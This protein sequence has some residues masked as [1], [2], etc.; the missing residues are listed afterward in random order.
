MT[1]HNRKKKLIKPALQ[2]KLAGIFMG[3]ALAVVS[4]QAYTLNKTTL[5]LASYLPNDQEL[6]RKLWPD[7]FLQNTALA[8]LLILVAMFGVGVAVTFRIAGPLYRFERYLRD[9]RDGT[10]TGPCNLRAN[11]DLKEFCDLLNE[12]TAPVRARNQAAQDAAGGDNRRA[13]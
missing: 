5:A 1:K 4:I 8:G 10:E 9:L 3:A 2:L 11:D 12:A 6:F 7:Y 13:A